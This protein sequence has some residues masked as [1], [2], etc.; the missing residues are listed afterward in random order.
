MILFLILADRK[1]LWLETMFNIIYNLNKSWNP[2]LYICGIGCTN[3]NFTISSGYIQ[4]IN[5][6]ILKYW[7]AIRQ[8]FMK[9]VNK[10]VQT[11]YL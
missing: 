10:I 4:Q 5:M 6:H 9:A 3:K 1:L 8:H 11:P 2:S 7:L